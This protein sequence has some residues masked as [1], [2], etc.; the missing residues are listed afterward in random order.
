MIHLTDE[1]VLAAASEDRLVDIVSAPGSGKTTVAAE[2]FGFYRYQRGDDR[3]VL[4]LTFNRAAANELSQRVIR[5]WG[6]SC[7]AYPH[8]VA[9]FDHLYVDM[10]H[11]LLNEQLIHWPGGHEHLDVR[12]E[13]RGLDGFTYLTPD[14]NWRR[15]ATLDSGRRVVSGSRKVTEP[16]RGVG[17]KAKHEAI[18][19]QGIV[20]HEDVRQILRAALKD[21]DLRDRISGWIGSNYRAIVIDEVYDADGLDLTVARI[22]ADIGLAVTI[23]GDPWQALYKWRGAK[24]QLVAKLLEIA[25]GRFVRRNLSKSFRFSGSQMPELAATLRE[26]V[27]ASLPAITSAE[28]DVALARRWRDLWSV[29]DNVLPLAFRNVENHSDAA[30]LLL[31]DV[32]TKSRLGEHAHG[33]ESAIAKLKLDRE[34][35]LA[36]QRDLMQPLLG[37]L[38]AGED[39]VVILDALRETIKSLGVRRP[40]RLGDANK[41]AALVAQLGQIGMRLQRSDLIPGLTVF[42]A[43]G[44]EWPR[45]GI[46][47]SASQASMLASGLQEDE[48]EHCIIYVA[49]T[50]AKVRCGRLGA[51]LQLDIESDDDGR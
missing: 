11:R 18:L 42:Q 29:G 27:G 4:G 34:A 39:P 21:T 24:P 7:V 33:R 47:L 28:I 15:Y 26:G 8:R 49:I 50:R 48:E 36:Q 40:S 20:D 16:T 25:A 9:T 3:G 45:V 22:A 43:K 31:L 38:V 2:R 30:I 41:E 10:V 12:D 6:E 46:V 19:E 35:F 5:R 13:Y 23:I 37:Q 32:I 1:Q 51:D 44:R 14:R 17:I